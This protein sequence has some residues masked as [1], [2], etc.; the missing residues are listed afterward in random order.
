[1]YSTLQS[2]C[3]Q[4][5]SRPCLCQQKA[6]AP[7]RNQLPAFS[8]AEDSF[9]LQAGIFQVGARASAPATTGLGVNKRGVPNGRSSCAQYSGSRRCSGT[10]CSFVVTCFGSRSWPCYGPFGTEVMPGRPPHCD[11]L[12]KNSLSRDA[13]AFIAVRFRVACDELINSIGLSGL[14]PTL[15]SPAPP[16]PEGP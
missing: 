14:H 5:R 15:P 13:L 3:R 8:V 1:M 2:R 4:L 11:S 9:V 10:P 7:R 12:T 16:Q 6:S